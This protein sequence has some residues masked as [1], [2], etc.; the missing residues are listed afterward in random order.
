MKAVSETATYNRV[1]YWVELGSFL[2][3][4]AKFYSDSGRL[5]KILYYRG[6]RQQLD[7]MRPTEAIIID[8]VDSSLVTTIGFGDRRYQDVPDTWFQRD[9]LPRLRVD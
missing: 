4:K 7:A 2:P 5:L 8:A 6:Y 1:E 9:Y 3:S